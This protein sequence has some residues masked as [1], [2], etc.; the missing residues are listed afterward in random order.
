MGPQE[1][2][3]NL[4]GSETMSSWRRVH[5]FRAVLITLSILLITVLA[6]IAESYY[7][8]AE[9]TKLV[10]SLSSVQVGYTTEADATQ[11]IRKFS[12]FCH[13]GSDKGDAWIETY[14]TCS[15]SLLSGYKLNRIS[16]VE[17]SSK[18]DWE[19]EA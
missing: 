4:K 15:F 6:G 11:I 14:D 1:N 7:E 9:A 3:Q 13:H 10:N 12:H 5:A 19:S 16:C 17:F 18:S 8:R 2:E